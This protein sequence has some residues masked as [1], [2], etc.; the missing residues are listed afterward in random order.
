MFLKQIFDVLKT[1]IF[2]LEASLL[3]QIFVLHV[4]TSNLFQPIVHR[5]KHSIVLIEISSSYPKCLFWG[6]LAL[7]KNFVQD[8][9]AEC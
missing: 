2:A 1:N 6:K 9:K 8:E 4:R 5:Q 3:R 7:A